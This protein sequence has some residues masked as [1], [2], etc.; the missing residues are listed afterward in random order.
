MTTEN[1][2]VEYNVERALPVDRLDDLKP[3]TSA[4]FG[5]TWRSQVWYNEA[6]MT[7]TGILMD[8]AELNDDFRRAFLKEHKILVQKYPDDPN[9]NDKIEKDVWR[10]IL[11][12]ELPELNEELESIGLSA[13]Q[14]GTAEQTARRN[15]RE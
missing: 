15:L 3:D 8:A 11:E 7:A 12:D 4:M 14:G 13:F 1:S 9:V 10:L 5:V 2:N 6:V